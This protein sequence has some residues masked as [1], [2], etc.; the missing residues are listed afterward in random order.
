MCKYACMRVCGT[1]GVYPQ[2]CARSGVTAEIS[3]TSAYAKKK[4][5]SVN[6]HVRLHTRLWHPCRSVEAHMG[7]SW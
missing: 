4:E 5:K 3:N 1:H 2:L 7:I 6:V